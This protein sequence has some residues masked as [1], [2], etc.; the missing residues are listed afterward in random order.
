MH[1]ASLHSKASLLQ[2]RIAAEQ[3]LSTLRSASLCRRQRADH[4]Q[5][6]SGTSFHHACAHRTARSAVTCAGHFFCLFCFALFAL[7]AAIFQERQK[8]AKASQLQGRGTGEVCVHQPSALPCSRSAPAAALSS[9]LHRAQTAKA[10]C[11]F[12][13]HGACCKSLFDRC[14]AGATD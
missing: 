7:W 10:D 12:S 5:Q 14:N 9:L 11:P 3:F 1:S 6:H 4:V 8:S 2:H 13:A